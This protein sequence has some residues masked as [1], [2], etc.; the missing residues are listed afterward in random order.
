MS[1]ARPGWSGCRSR[2]IF[3]AL[4]LAALQAPG[5]AVAQDAPAGAETGHVQVGD[6][7]PD[8][9]RVEDI[10]V[11]GVR[12]REAAAAYVSRVAAPVAD[13]GV[14]TWAKPVCVGVANIEAGAA[15][16]MA[17]RISD[18]AA[19]VGLEIGPPGCEPNVFVVFA[20]DA[21]RAAQDLVAAR[22]RQFATGVSGADLGS[23]A[24]ERFQSS[25]RPVR[26]WHVSLPTDPATGEPIRRLPGVP[27]VDW[28]GRRL[29]RLSDFGINQTRVTSS[30][31]T[32]DLRDDLQRVVV[33]VDARALDVATFGQVADYVALV[34]LVQVNPELDPVGLDSVLS[35]FSDPARAPLAMTGWDRAYLRSVYAAEQTSRNPATNT[36]ELARLM[37]AR[38]QA[39]QDELPEP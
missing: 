3:A 20:A 35:L 29:S 18:W 24:L 36:G 16:L 12:D 10:V 17:D 7:D 19:Y 6:Q 39:E 26:W 28:R 15:Q 2:A 4:A 9:T 37:V 21:D 23:R 25:S 22:P 31:L 1:C 33:V 11:V 14:A 5:S 27:P 30:R 32:Q 13:R 34:A 38:L 8:T